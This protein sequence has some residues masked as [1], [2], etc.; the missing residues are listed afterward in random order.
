MVKPPAIDR[1]RA[2]NRRRLLARLRHHGPLSRTELALKSHLSSATVSAITGELVQAGRLV[3]RGLET[4]QGPVRGRPQVP[5]AF[6]PGFASVQAAYLAVDRVSMVLADY[7]GRVL[8][9]RHEAPVARAT[10]SAELVATLSHGLEAQR[11]TVD[12]PAVHHVVVAVQG[13]VDA[14]GERI[15]WTPIL[16]RA[17]LDVTAD[18]ARALGSPVHLV[19]DAMAIVEGLGPTGD[20]D[21]GVLLLGYGVGMGLV[22]GGRP[23]QGH[24][25]SALELGHVNH[26]PEGALCRCGRRGCLEAYTADYAIVRTAGRAAP[27]DTAHPSAATMAAVTAAAVAGEPAASAA[28]AAAGR[29]L[30][31]GLARAMALLGPFPVHMVGGTPTTFRLLE[32]PMRRGVEDALVP[33]LGEGLQL[34]HHID[35]KGLTL[36]GAL[37]QALRAVDATALMETG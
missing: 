14:L 36:A 8:D 33:A 19:N 3:H 2:D 12:G 6:A 23:V 7:G 26:V 34:V 18:L 16:D 31:F 5:L 24:G 30:G 11:A 15:V 25:H 4:A 1:I 21:F 13:V 20:D 35:S 27:D 17:G 32:G 10:G 37:T 29:A 9:R 28:F 22:R